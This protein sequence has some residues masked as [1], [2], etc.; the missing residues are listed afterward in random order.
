MLNLFNGMFFLLFFL[1]LQS[2]QTVS[3]KEKST[4]E[5]SQ[6]ETVYYNVQLGLAYLKKGDMPR[7]KKKLLDALDRQPNSAEANG[8]M[9]Y[10]LEKT[11]DTEGAEHYYKKALVLANHKGSELNNYGAFLCRQGRYVQAEEYFLRAT[12]DEYYLHSAG[13]FENAG[14]CALAVPD[15]EKARGYFEK[16]LKQDPNRSQS[17]YELVC[18]EIKNKRPQ[19]A[20]A[21]LQGHEGLLT[22]AT[23]LNLAIKA[24]HQ[25]GQHDAES[26]YKTSLNR[27]NSAQNS[28][29]NNE[30]DNNNSR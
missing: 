15:E 17:L 3:S 10:F 1:L 26:H 24:A 25:A 16:A 20:F 4:A 23:L 27:F 22:N 29:D 18:L 7:A 28:G 6:A 19:Q 13:A 21:Y 14:L 30:H 8:A 5:H 11:A 12:R 9:A 2:C